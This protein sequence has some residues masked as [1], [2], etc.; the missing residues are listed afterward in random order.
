MEADYVALYEKE[1]FV[2][3]GKMARFVQL[4]GPI[5][6]P[7]ISVAL[8]KRSKGSGY[9]LT[10]T[11]PTKILAELVPREK[12]VRLPALLVPVVRKDAPIP[13]STALAVHKL[14]LT[15]LRRRVPPKFV[16]G[17]GT[18]EIFS[19]VGPD[20]KRLHAALPPGAGKTT[21]ELAKIGFLLFDYCYDPVSERA[22]KAREIE[23]KVSS[24]QRRVE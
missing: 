22:K 10:A 16:I 24:L 8:D 1:L 14:W 21:L 23:K 4:P 15:M 13:K 6:Q 18:T 11:K 20:G 9:I 17:E 5:N 7:E 12:N 19:A 3:P 2:T